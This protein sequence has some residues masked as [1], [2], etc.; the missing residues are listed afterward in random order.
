MSVVFK[1]TL[2]EQSM[3]HL[4]NAYGPSKG[5]NSLVVP[6]RMISIVSSLNDILPYTQQQS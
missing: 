5:E 6:P 4:L 3:P 2:I 1:S